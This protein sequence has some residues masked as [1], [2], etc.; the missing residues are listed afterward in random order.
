[1]DIVQHLTTFVC[2]VDSGSISGAARKLGLSVPM[3]SRH[4]RALEVELGAP[5]L[6]RTTR[7]MD[8]TPAGAELLPRARRLLVGL[9][10]ARQAVRPGKTAAGH[11]TVS[12]P[13]SFG[14]A[15]VAPLVPRL[16]QK[17]PLL[18]VDVRYDDRVV[19]LL[20]DGVD[21]ALRVGVAA[22][23]SPFLVARRLASYDRVVCATPSFL[24]RHGPID[25]VETL[26]RVPCLPLGA[27][28][29][30]W[31]F[32]TPSGARSVA[33][34]G[35]LRSNN[36]LALRDAA[37]QGVGVA[38]LPGWLIAEDLQARRLV[39]VLADAALPTV[40]V[41]GLVH[42]EARHSNAL[43]LL[44]DFLAAELPPMLRSAP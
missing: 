25:E 4:L 34:S 1:M 44:Q 31:E 42:S 26:L 39:R 37:L 35:R 22:P 11:L 29:T 16:I 17:H 8:L 32:E 23:D 7:R 10:E 33:V 9:D 43:R 6:R 19:D 40:H 38:V 24:K 13:V 27:S 3:A 15:K 28:P 5:L 12:V 41:L 20:G 36:V 18:S 21:F 30:R 14:L 2:I